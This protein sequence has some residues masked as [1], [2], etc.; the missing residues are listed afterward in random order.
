MLYRQRIMQNSNKLEFSTLWRMI[1]RNEFYSIMVMEHIVPT[2][3]YIGRTLQAASEF[4][5]LYIIIWIFNWQNSL[6]LPLIY[7]VFYSKI[8]PMKLSCQ[9]TALMYVQENQYCF[10][11]SLKRLLQHSVYFSHANKA[12]LLLPMYLVQMLVPV[13][14]NDT[15]I[16]INKSLIHEFVYTTLS[17]HWRPSEERMPS[18]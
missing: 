9:V 13:W 16:L 1:L 11:F 4:M 7:A 8:R 17:M 2:F 6:H 15:I 18:W 5:T 12:R 10:S 14:N 3:K